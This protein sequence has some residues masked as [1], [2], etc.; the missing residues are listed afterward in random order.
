MS[1]VLLARDRNLYPVN[2]ILRDRLCAAAVRSDL[3]IPRHYR[4]KISFYITHEARYTIRIAESLFSPTTASS[5]TSL[6][7]K[8]TLSLLCADILDNSVA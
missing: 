2:A 5:T 3:R 4:R 6:K 8:Q 7:R 1:T